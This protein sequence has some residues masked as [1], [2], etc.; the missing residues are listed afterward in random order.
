MIFFLALKN[1]ISSFAA[2]DKKKVAWFSAHTDR[3]GFY[4]LDG[5]FRKFGFLKKKPSSLAVALFQQKQPNNVS[6]STIRAAV[7]MTNALALAWDIPL[8]SV[9]L[10]GEETKEEIIEKVR[11]VSLKAKKGEWV[12]AEYSGEPTITKAKSVFLSTKL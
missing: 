8:C 9:L 4:K 10:T 3:E 6:W 5:A 2:I 11:F 1:D 12:K 7:A